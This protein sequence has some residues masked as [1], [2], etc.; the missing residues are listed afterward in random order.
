MN[1]KLHEEMESRKSEMTEHF[2]VKH[3][4]GLAKAMR[5]AGQSLGKK[6]L[7]DTN[8]GDRKTAKDRMKGHRGGAIMRV[9][10]RL[11]K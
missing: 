9:L 7:P 5:H 6:E 4:T 10:K 11:K 1:K 3:P 2:R 8:F